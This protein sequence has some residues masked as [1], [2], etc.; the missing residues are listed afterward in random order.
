MVDVNHQINAV[1]RTIGS[2]TL[3]AGEARVLTIS[4]AYDT[5]LE[6]LWD[7]CTSIERIPRWLMPITGELRLG[8]RYQL[9]GNAGGV[10]ERCDPPKGFAVTW[11][12]NGEVSWVE[13]RLSADP[14]GRSRIEIEHVAHV[15]DEMWAQ[16]GPGAVGIGWDSMLLGL[17]LY[18]ASD[19]SVPP[20]KGQEWS[21]SPE[22]KQFIDASS[23]RWAEASIAAGTPEQEA[24]TAA[25]TVAKLYK[26]E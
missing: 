22:G 15:Q 14:D 10:V 25:E 18:L 11:E 5:D 20:E 3:E 16:F 6:D 26:G 8:G 13:V 4:Q 17:S 24:R 1:R 23:A 21:V 7:A 19:T 12:M 2:R 9:V